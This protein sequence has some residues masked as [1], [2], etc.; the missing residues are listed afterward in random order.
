M[1]RWWQANG[2]VG[3][4]GEA[5]VQLLVEMGD[6]RLESTMVGVGRVS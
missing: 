1:V 4:L 2:S 6:K 3:G 5:V